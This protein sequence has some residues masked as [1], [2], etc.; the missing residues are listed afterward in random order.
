M[1]SKWIAWFHVVINTR[2]TWLHGDPRG[3]RDRGHRIH[4]SGDYKHPPPPGEHAALHRHYLGKS[5]AKVVLSPAECERVAGVVIEQF[6]RYGCRLLALAVSPV[7]AHLLVELHSDPT[8]R[9][10]I[11]GFVKR[12]AT[13]AL[14][15]G[16]HGRLWAQG[17]LFK[18]IR[19][20]EHHL[21]TFRYIST[22]QR[23]AWVWSFRES[24]RWVE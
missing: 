4:S 8:V 7:H 23:C 18:V 2:N 1:S 16:R 14:Q 5:G 24:L 19:D 3:F 21:N 12:A 9:K 10:R 13:A 11:L 22:Q 20:R 15:P 17:A 6:S